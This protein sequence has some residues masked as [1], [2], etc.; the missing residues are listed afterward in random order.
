MGA[1]QAKRLEHY[2]IQPRKFLSGEEKRKRGEDEP[3]LSC[4]FPNVGHHA[5]LAYLQKKRYELMLLEQKLQRESQESEARLNAILTPHK[6]S[7]PP[8]LSESPETSPVSLQSGGMS[9]ITDLKRIEQ[10]QTQTQTQKFEL[11]SSEQRLLQSFTADKTDGEIQQ[12]R[13]NAALIGAT[14]G[15]AV[16]LTAMGIQ[17]FLTYT[18]ESLMPDPQYKWLSLALIMLLYIAILYFF[19]AFFCV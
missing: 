16:I 1:K 12:E 6:P 17:T 4:R 14:L 2:S 19:V 13:V 10:G 3:R 5:A 15:T 18:L 9:G 7:L 8:E 11:S